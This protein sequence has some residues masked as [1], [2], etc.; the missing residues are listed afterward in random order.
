MRQRTE[1]RQRQS[2]AFNAKF[3]N[4]VR[5]LQMPNAEL[6]QEVQAILDSNPLLEEVEFDNSASA[7][8]FFAFPTLSPFA[9]SRSDID[10]DQIIEYAAQ[11][12]Y[13]LTIRDHLRNQIQLSG[14][15]NIKRQIALAIADSI[16]E[17]GYLAEPT[18]EICD[19]LAFD[20]SVENVDDVLAFVQRLDPPGIA[21]RSLK[22]CLAIQLEQN[23]SAADENSIA[24]AIVE[25]CLAEVANYQFE[26]IAEKLGISYREVC[27]AV[28]LIQAL[29]PVPG[30][31]FGESAKIIVPDVIAKKA[32]NR[33]LVA[34]NEE[35]LPKIRI[36]SAYQ[37]MIGVTDSRQ[38]KRYLKKN[39]AGANIFLDSINRRHQ[40][41][42]RVARE[43]VEHQQDFLEHGD[44]QMRPLTL[45]NVADTLGLHESTV[46]RAS[47]AKYIMTPRG[48]FELKAL[49]S[50]RINRIA[51][52]DVSAKSVQHEIAR[53]IENEDCSNPLSDQKITDHLHALDIQIARRTVVKYRSVMNIPT[54]KIRKI[55]K[56]NQSK[57]VR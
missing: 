32:N 17:R 46:S 4:T 38:G 57:I 50:G 5:I 6:K 18:D 48:T 42:L 39:L 7:E 49:F 11:K 14:L 25:H 29:N 36:S 12:N 30:A 43:L 3:S 20:A 52:G 26:Q 23:S 37:S 21:A 28:D 54:R 41:I 31:G 22:Q 16:D 8:N 24:A 33:W 15:D 53:L 47:S 2:P 27:N 51:G 19:M 9:A 45:Q 40:T 35:V 55:K 34:L 13:S 1:L 56:L 10:S 44:S